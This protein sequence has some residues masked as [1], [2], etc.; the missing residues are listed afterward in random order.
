[1]EGV[2]DW[3]VR[4]GEVPLSPPPRLREHSPLDDDTDGH[5]SFTDNKI[6][7]VAFALE[8][9]DGRGWAS[10]RT[11]RCLAVDPLHPAR[12]RAYCNI[13]QAE[14]TFRV[15]RIISIADLRTGRILSSNEQLALLAPYL[16]DD[17][18]DPDFP[19]LSQ[20][21]DVTRDGVFALLQLAMQ[22]NGRLGTAARVSVLNYVKAEAQALRSVVPAHAFID[23]W[24][25]NLSPSL[26]AVAESV[27][28]LLTDKDKFARLLPWLLKVMRC[29]EAFAQQDEA[30]RELIA[31]VRRHFRHRLFEWPDDIRAT[32]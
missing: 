9:C 17:L 20:L 29:Q 10:L 14:R 24:V 19:A 12:F 22:P 27:G 2:V 32:R 4:R 15:D 26:D 5:N 7:G 31:E 13:R 28:N 11:V 6:R 3:F 23:I 30:V 1:M 25:D 18:A 8:Y 16:H 21:Q